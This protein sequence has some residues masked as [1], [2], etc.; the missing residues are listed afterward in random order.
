ME[1]E[2]AGILP[3]GD[4]THVARSI[5]LRI[6]DATI[7]TPYVRLT[8]TLEGWAL[9]PFTDDV[10]PP[11]PVTT[12][13]ADQTSDSSPN[14]QLA[15]AQVHTD[16]GR[17]TIVDTAEDPPDPLAP[18]ATIDLAVSEGWTRDLRLPAVTLGDFALAGSDPWL[19]ALR[20][21]GTRG[22]GGR[23]L[24]LSGESVSLAAAAPFLVRAGLP[25]RLEG[26][27]ASFL[28]RIVVA[29]G[30][31]AADTTLS[32]REPMVAGDTAALQQALGTS[33]E[34]ALAELRDPNGDVT[35]HLTLAGPGTGDPRTL[36]DAVT[37]AVRDAVARGRQDLLPNTPLQIAFDPGSP[38]L[39]PYGARQI[40]VIAQALEARPDVVVELAAPV[41]TDDR[42]WF[43]EQA[44]AD[45]LEPTGG[46]K[47]V[48]RT[49][50]IRDR[51]ER[52][53]QAL[54]ERA[55]GRPG[56]LDPDDE[57]ALQ[58]MLA[59]RAPVDADRLAALAAAR[60]TRVTTELADRHDIAR[61]RVVIADVGPNDSPSPPAVRGTLEVDPRLTRLPAPAPASGAT[62]W[63][64]AT[65]WGAVR[66]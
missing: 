40:A 1:L 44:L 37:R 12:A 64:A 32:L 51:R 23:V 7:G 31:W 58:D 48:L 60:V 45:D 14:V 15:V 9:P 28:S 41:S 34:T 22:V 5:E 24:E 3:R 65:P 13:A 63:G 43:A 66:R 33:V 47:G 53:R 6:S 38:E 52:I 36:P 39:T 4:G 2:L 46:F 25:Y 42:R 54:K 16:G 21:E 17:V 19:G 35:L 62:T 50:G 20:L 55:D 18:P 29:A 59:H 26:G 27:T 61:A 49:F 10:G 57:A 11:A 56:R 8:R 30:R